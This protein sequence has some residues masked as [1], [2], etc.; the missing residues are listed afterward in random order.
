[1]RKTHTKF[2]PFHLMT[3][4]WETHVRGKYV[5]LSH[6][7]EEVHELAKGLGHPLVSAGF[8]SIGSIGRVTYSGESKSLRLKDRGSQRGM[9]QPYRNSEAQRHRTLPVLVLHTRAIAGKRQ[10]CRLSIPFALE[11][12][13]RIIAGFRIGTSGLIQPS[14]LALG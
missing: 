4:R 6:F 10:S 2:W 5:V 12:F 8:F 13:Q 14:A 11:H 9:V 3:K 1:M 7:G